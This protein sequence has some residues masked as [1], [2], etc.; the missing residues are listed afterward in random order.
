MIPISLGRARS[1]VP[2]FALSLFAACPADKS[3]TAIDTGANNSTIFGGA[4]LGAPDNHCFIAADGGAG[5]PLTARAT[6]AASCLADAG[7]PDDGGSTSDFGATMNGAGGNDDDCKYQVA[8]WSSPV[9]RNEDVTFHLTAVRTADGSL[10]TGAKPY[11][12]IFIGNNPATGPIA[13]EDSPGVYTIGP[14][15]FDRAGRWTVRFHLYGDCADTLPD[16]PHGHAA[17][18]VDVP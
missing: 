7:T 3:S 12:E 1:L 18:F 16:S 11:A 9:M 4:V 10:A 17:F 8:W 13:K 6:S 2:C 5:G 14:V 15:R